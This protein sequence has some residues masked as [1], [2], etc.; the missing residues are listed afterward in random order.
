M[1]R[2]LAIAI[3][4]VAFDALWTA[5][6]LGAGKAWWWAAPAMIVLSMAGQLRSSPAPGR[7]T[8]LILGGA[9]IG[10]SLDFLGVSLGV[11][12]YVS[13]STVEFLVLFGALWVNFGTTLRPTLR[14]MW[15][16]PVLAAVF[17]AIGGPGAYWIGSRIGAVSL[18]SPEWR[19]LLW[20]TAQ[21]GAALPLWMLVA[22]RTI[23]ERDGTGL[24]Q[25]SHGAMR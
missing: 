18:G 20:V 4:V 3:N 23:G 19:G 10:T 6:M 17:G 22:N 11:L 9:A 24:R 12:R 16:R 25:T 14:W 15:R 7:E 8:C 21:Y 1:K 13:D 2:W 5:G